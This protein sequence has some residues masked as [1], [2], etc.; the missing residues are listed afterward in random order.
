[1]GFGAWENR[2]N[3]PIPDLKTENKEI[4][5]LGIIFCRDINLAIDLTWSKIICNIRIITRML[6]SRY[7]TL[8]QRAVV[9]N[10][11]LLSKVWYNAHTYPLIKK[12]SDKIL[13]E[14]FEYLWHSRLNLIRIEKSYTK[15]KQRRSG[16]I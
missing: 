7:L 15:A 14:V 1:M 16:E 2:E 13:K 3:W 4:K 9:I 12:Y 5:I 11:I 10:S 6:S 8:Y